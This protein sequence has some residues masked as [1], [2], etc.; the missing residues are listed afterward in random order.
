MQ[1]QDGISTKLN[2]SAN[3]NP[4]AFTMIDLLALVGIVLLLASIVLPAVSSHR[5]KAKA[6]ACKDDLKQIGVAFRTWALD[7][8]D[9]YPSRVTI[10]NGGAK[11]QI[12]LGNVFFNFLVMSNEIGSPKILVCPEDIEKTAIDNFTP[13]LSNTN[14]SYFVGADAEDTFPQMLLT[15]DRNLAFQGHPVGPGLFPVTSN[16][17]A[18][19]WT[20]TIHN[21]RGN[22]GLA[23]GS[24]QTLD[25]KRLA[26]AAAGQDYATN[27]LAIP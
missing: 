14:V 8:G 15:G 13:A 20:K 25:S 24:V 12:E 5:R 16:R 18:L 1:I 22:I 19:S 27:R 10:D 2:H 4:R 9:A 3:L 23:D 7:C 21:E 6:E 11:E 17:I 26:L